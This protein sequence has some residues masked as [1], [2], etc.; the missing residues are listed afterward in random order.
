VV[1]Q[2][3]YS[4]MLVINVCGVVSVVFMGSEKFRKPNDWDKFVKETAGG[5][6]NARTDLECVSCFDIRTF[7]LHSHILVAHCNFQS[8][9]LSSNNNKYSS[10]VHF[11]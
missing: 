5:E 11:M 4:L 1:F 10:F 9:A 3:L 8:H 7:R 2:K 6:G